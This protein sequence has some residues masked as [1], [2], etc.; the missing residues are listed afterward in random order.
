MAAS[1]GPIDHLIPLT[2]GGDLDAQID[3]RATLLLPSVDSG[4]LIRPRTPGFQPYPHIPLQPPEFHQLLVPQLAAEIQNEGVLNW[5]DT[6]TPA[7][8]KMA[9]ALDQALKPAMPVQ[10]GG[11]ELT[12]IQ[13]DPIFALLLYLA[14]ALGTI[15]LPI[16]ARYTILWSVLLLA[17]L[18]LTL[19]D[20]PVNP[21]RSLDIFWGMGLGLAFSIPFLLLNWT[22]L[23]ITSAMLYPFD[24][25]E[26]LFI[27]LILIAPL[28]ES[29]FFRGVLQEKRG[30]L[31]SILGVGLSSILFFWPALYQ[32]PVN[33]AVAVLVTTVFAAIYA[34]LKSSISLV[35]AVA[36]QV[37]L[38]LMIF[39]IPSLFQ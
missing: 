11:Q 4:R 38:N 24:H 13:I 25:W 28:A 22:G 30:Y 14:V 2:L 23:G 10:A 9:I 33:F 19:V 16:T 31:I 5:R 26:S 17:G 21:I 3:A 6:L 34:F 36:C 37:I 27:A 29:L 7:D 18:I 32:H 39:M 15:T 12:G 20:R 1:V 8:E 35:A